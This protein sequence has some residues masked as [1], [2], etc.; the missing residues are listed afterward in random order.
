MAVIKRVQ[1]AEKISVQL[2]RDEQGLVRIKWDGLVMGE[3]IAQH[4][5]T[6][7]FV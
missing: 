5:L 4:V 2:V 7:A 1:D 6:E 3:G